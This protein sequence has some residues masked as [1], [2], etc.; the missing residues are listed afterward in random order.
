MMGGRVGLGL[1][2]LHTDTRF[3][4]QHRLKKLYFYVRKRMYLCMYNW[5]TLH[6][7][8]QQKLAEHCK[9]T[10]IKNEK[11]NPLFSP[12]D[13]LG[14]L[15]KNQLRGVPAVAQWDWQSICSTRLQVL[16]PPSTPAPA[17]AVGY[18][19]LCCRLAQ[20]CSKD[21]I[22]GLG[23]PYATGWPIKKKKKKKNHLSFFVL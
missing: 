18:Q 21:L 20:N 17:C 9:S 6:F 10:I 16:F 7:A 15:I 14:N 22:F 8:I 1:F 11:K 3:F 23:T 13:W 19:I 4:Q 2:S 5:V 12:L